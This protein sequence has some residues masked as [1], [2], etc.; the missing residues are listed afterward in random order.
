MWERSNQTARYL[1]NGK[2]DSCSRNCSAAAGVSGNA[3]TCGKE[4]WSRYTTAIKKTGK[5][6]V[7]SLIGNCDPAR[8]EQPWKWGAEFTNSWRTNIDAQVGWQAVPYLVDCQR[9]M[10]GNGSWCLANGSAWVDGPNGWAQ[11][12]STPGDGGEPCP[13]SAGHLPGACLAPATEF[14]GPQQF[15]GNDGGKGGHWNDMDMLTI[16]SRSYLFEYKVNETTGEVISKG[17]GPGGSALT[18]SQSRAQLSMWSIMKSPLLISLDANEVATWP[19][20]SKGGEPGTGLDLLAVLKN[21]EVLAVSDDPLGLEAF[22]LE[23]IKGTKS[24]IGVFVGQ[25]QAGKFAVVMF[26]RGGGPNKMTLAL[27]D[28]KIVNPKA[29][30]SSYKVR[31]LWAHSDNGTVASGSSLSASVSGED[32]VMLTLTPV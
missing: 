30:A 1:C 27:S 19:A 6:M 12:Q 31:D 13:C 29:T 17:A 11:V 9:R 28:L 18:V 8:G 10:A 23:D 15:S 14:G 24:S 25:M 16:G 22:R 2:V 4:L 20:D 21:E 7:Y 26:S 5:D 3:S 32:A